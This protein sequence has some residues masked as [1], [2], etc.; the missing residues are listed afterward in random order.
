MFNISNS[1]DMDVN[2]SFGTFD[3]VS[4]ALLGPNEMDLQFLNSIPISLDQNVGLE[5]AAVQALSGGGVNGDI[6][7][8]QTVQNIQTCQTFSNGFVDPQTF[9]NSFVGAPMDS[10]GQMETPPQ[11]VSPQALICQSSSVNPQTFEST[12]MFDFGNQIQP[13]QV[14]QFQPQLQTQPQAFTTPDLLLQQSVDFG[15]TG[16]DQFSEGFGQSFNSTFPE[17]DNQVQPVAE[18]PIQPLFNNQV[19]P[20]LEYPVQTQ[21]G[22][23]VQ[24]QPGNR[25]QAQNQVQL[26]SVS[27]AK[28][29]LENAQSQ[30]E[31]SKLVLPSIPT[32]NPICTPSRFQNWEPEMEFYV[33]LRFSP[34]NKEDM[35][36]YKSI[37]QRDFDKIQCESELV[38]ELLYALFPNPYPSMFDVAAQ[39]E[40]PTKEK[41]HQYRYTWG[42]KDDVY[43]SMWYRIDTLGAEREGGER[44]CALCKSWHK[45]RN[46]S[47]AN[48]QS[49]VHG[50]SAVTKSI[51]PFPT[52][53]ILDGKSVEP[54]RS[55]KPRSE[56]EL[57]LKGWCRKCNS[58]VHLFNKQSGGKY[59]TWF[60][61]QDA[62]FRQEMQE[63]RGG[64]I[65]T[66]N[67]PRNS[68]KRNIA[69]TSSGESTPKTQSASPSSSKSSEPAAEPANVESANEII[70]AQL[71]LKRRRVERE[72]KGKE[73][74]EEED[75]GKEKEEDEE[76]V[77]EVQQVEP[78]EP[79]QQVIEIAD[80][81]PATNDTTN[82]DEDEDD[83][84]SEDTIGNLIDEIEAEDEA[85]EAKEAEADET[86]QTPDNADN[87]DN[88]D[89][90]ENPATVIA[91]DTFGDTK[92]PIA[93][94]NKPSPANTEETV[95]ETD[96]VPP[97][98][99]IDFTQ[100][101]F[102]C[103]FDEADMFNMGIDMSGLNEIQM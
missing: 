5:P 48:H 73:K 44:Y 43:S 40:S 10:Q 7:G 103:D 39:E 62:H 74:E 82:E 36:K 78:V 25:V 89:N 42:R 13:T 49:S 6:N 20:Q 21:L 76:E 95:V 26:G 12:Q 23:Q 19:Q 31:N 100:N 93:D 69:Q 79:E 63:K 2:D 32:V 24:T 70:S 91:T 30:P 52:G 66:P 67:N 102:I 84:F 50:I 99:T 97:V 11:T 60:R 101:P 33:P 57:K 53:V 83:Y 51:Y 1:A 65:H 56:Q 47:W 16:F 3:D 64:K 87:A 45:T 98:P 34:N 75:K 88:A 72:D 96:S 85:N 58:F 28:P 15:I 37:I 80:D 46:H 27:P 9:L 55:K 4:S 38:R 8:S 92:D 29:Q 71:N 14:Q 77:V 18:Y 94:N 90:P 61:H 35:D 59:T 81:T 68:K 22:N 86:T 41:P 54:D 17:I